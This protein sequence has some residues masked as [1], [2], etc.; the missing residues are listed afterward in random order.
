MKQSL[1][2]EIIELKSQ[3]FSLKLLYLPLISQEEQ[4]SSLV[5]KTLKQTQEYMLFALFYQL[6]SQIMSNYVEELEGKV[7][8]VLL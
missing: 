5:V 8:T 3:L 1:K 6:H 2:T 4:I 7:K